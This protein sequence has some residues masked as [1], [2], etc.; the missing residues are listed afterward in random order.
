MNTPIFSIINMKYIGF[1]HQFTV[2]IVFISSV[3][4][5]TNLYNNY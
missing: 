4:F 5:I 3:Q 1:S 2:Q